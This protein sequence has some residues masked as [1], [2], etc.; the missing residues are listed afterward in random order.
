MSARDRLAELRGE[1]QQRDELEDVQ[2]VESKDAAGSVPLDR[3]ST[4]QT[5]VASIQ[6][7][8]TSLTALSTQVKSAASSKKKKAIID[9]LDRLKVV[10][11]KSAKAARK[12]L[13]DSAKEDDKY[14]REH[15]AKTAS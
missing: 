5:H 6:S 14:A 1:G 7:V 4:L 13:D 11:F 8:I 10:A 12:E 3:Y 9:E 2:L 15:G